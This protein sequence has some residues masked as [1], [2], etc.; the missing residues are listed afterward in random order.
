MRAA[1]VCKSCAAINA[2][3]CNCWLYSNELFGTVVFYSDSPVYLFGL[4]FLPAVLSALHSVLCQYAWH[5]DQELYL[6]YRNNRNASRLRIVI[7]IR[8]TSTS[9]T[10]WFVITVTFAFFHMKRKLESEIQTAIAW[11]VLA[12]LINVLQLCG[13]MDDCCGCNCCISCEHY[14]YYWGF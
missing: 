9:F 2:N 10:F 3:C 8:I 13:P 7:P 14:Y 1:G 6:L 12:T 4:K 5:S 11:L